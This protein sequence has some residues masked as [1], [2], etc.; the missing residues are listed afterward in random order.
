MQYHRRL[1]KFEYLA[2]K[3][4]EE[5]VAMLGSKKSEVRIMAGGTIV[6]HQMKE[7]IG[8]WPYLMSLKQIKDLDYVTFG[9]KKKLRIGSITSLQ[10]VA[11]SP[12]INEKV[13]VLAHA[14]RKLGTPQ[15]RNMGTIGGNL[16]C[17]FATAETIPVLIALGAE[18]SIA[19]SEGIRTVSMEDFY[20]ELKDGELLTEILVPLPTANAKW[21]YRKFAVREHYDFATVSAATVLNID[22]GKFADVRLALGGVT[23]PTMRAKESEK[24]LSGQ[25]VKDDMI[26]KAAQ[27]AS[28]SGNLGSDVYFSAD[29][30]KDLLRVVAKR[31]LKDA[32]GA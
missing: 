26:V 16:S 28:E 18:A 2:P 10:S 7:R 15:L 12:V 32:V 23:L 30:K 4:V 17:R 24:L 29:Y 6:V 1:P 27:I 19:S 11:G 3:T 25:S 8:K 22:K 20:K 9:D 14:C 21:G 5:A 13:P 31:A